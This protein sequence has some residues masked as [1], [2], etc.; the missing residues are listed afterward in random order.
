MKSDITKKLQLRVSDYN[1]EAMAAILDSQDFTSL[2][3]VLEFLLQKN[4]SK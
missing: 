2:S 4:I 3:E 1:L